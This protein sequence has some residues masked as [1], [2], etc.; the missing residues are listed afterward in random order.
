LSDKV[1]VLGFDALS[2]GECEEFEEMTG[3]SVSSLEESAVGLPIKAITVLVW[4]TKRRD[5][6][7]SSLED[8]RK[9]KISDLDFGSDAEPNPTPEGSS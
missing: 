4:L 7:D 8:A 5:D 6:P 9:L 3:V 2:L 1:K